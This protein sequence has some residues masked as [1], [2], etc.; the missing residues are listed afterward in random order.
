VRSFLTDTE[1][2][3]DGAPIV[4]AAEPLVV[5]A[6]LEFGRLG[7]LLHRVEGGEEG[8]RVYP[9]AHR[10]VELAGGRHVVA[11]PWMWAD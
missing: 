8:G 7:R 3:G 5:G 6:E 9:V 1:E 10:I 2:V 4:G 11:S